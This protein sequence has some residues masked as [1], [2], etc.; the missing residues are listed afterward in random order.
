MW[1]KEKDYAWYSSIETMGALD[2]PGLRLVIFLQGC[3]LRC[4][5]CHNPETIEWKEDKKISIDEIINMYRKNESFYKKEGGITISGG[6]GMGQPDFL[7]NLLERTIDEEIHV[8][9]DTA[10][11]SY[12][13][14]N[15]EKI[16]RIALLANL[17]LIDIKH[18]DTDVARELTSRGNETQIE[19]IEYLESIKKPYWVRHV[20]VPTYSDRNEDSMFSLGEYIGKLRYMERFEI[21]PYHNMMI[22]KYEE[23][24]IPFKLAHIEPPSEAT[25]AEAMSD[26][27]KGIKKTRA[28]LT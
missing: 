16:N 5:F 2:G 18:I 8:T 10:V 22:A 9:I 21:L 3:P 24:K 19:F 14:R 13:G 17:F 12:M 28:T 1:D 6:E 4:L 15:I 23:M 11:G 27:N 25:I 20:F 26:I 7:I